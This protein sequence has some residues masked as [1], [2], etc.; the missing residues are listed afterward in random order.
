MLRSTR[1][2]MYRRSY[3]V[4]EDGRAVAVLG[5][6]RRESCV[7][8][9]DGQEYLVSRNRYRSFTLSGSAGELARAEKDS[10]RMW[11]IRSLTD[12]LELVRTS[13]W[14]YSWELRRF[15]EV[16]GVVGTDGPFK[17]TSTADLPPEL[18]LP[19]RLFVLYVV[20]TLWARSSQAASAGA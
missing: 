17:R 4:S 1:R 14:K 13:L 5:V 12:Q 10:G 8:Q 20:E 7:F 2:G 9:V 16:V 15:G 18:P 19:L 6:G 11:T 3:E